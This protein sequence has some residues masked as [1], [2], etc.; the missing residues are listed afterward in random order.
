M[1]EILAHVPQNIFLADTSITRN[2]AFGIPFQEIDFNLVKKVA[3][4]AQ[5]L[6]FIE[7]L[8]YGF[9][10]R[11]GERGV[12]LSGGQ[13]QRI[14]I[15]RALYKK[16]QILILDEATSALDISTEKSVMRSIDELNN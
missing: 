11:V 5:L 8:K 15:A 4:D 16:A 10:T 7:N 2:I 14:G 9:E 13:K 6:D 12:Q 3:S 1:E